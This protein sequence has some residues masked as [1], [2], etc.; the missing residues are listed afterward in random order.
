MTDSK[1]F[2]SNIFCSLWSNTVSMA[3]REPQ[4][5]VPVADWEHRVEARFLHKATKTVW[6]RGSSAIRQTALPKSAEY[7][8]TLGRS[9]S[10][11]SQHASRPLFTPILMD[12]IDAAI[13]HRALSLSLLDSDSCQCESSSLKSV[14]MNPTATLKPPLRASFWNHV[15]PPYQD[16]KSNRLR[17]RCR[18]LLLT[19]QLHAI[20]KDMVV[21]GERTKY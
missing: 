16:T 15:L 12:S 2:G 7:T 11:F 14:G 3:D 13:S 6:C 9:I 5:S 1:Y 10:N 20:C 21:S 4:M 17:R 18:S 8:R 19:E